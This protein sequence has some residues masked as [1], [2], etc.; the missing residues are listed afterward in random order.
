M[1]SQFLRK[2]SKQL[3]LQITKARKSINEIRKENNREYDR[4][5]RSSAKDDIIKMLNKS[6]IEKEQEI[7][8][9]RKEINE[10]VNSC[11]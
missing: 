1:V 7:S 6:L 5:L 3:N 8:E 2:P 11:L 9:L 4:L 10:W